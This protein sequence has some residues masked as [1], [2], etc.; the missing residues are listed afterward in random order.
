MSTK[1]IWYPDRSKATEK[2][3][4]LYL[5]VTAATA[6]TLKKAT[7]KIE[8]LMN[9]DLGSLAEDKRREKVSRFQQCVGRSYLLTIIVRSFDDEYSVNGQKRSSLLVWNP[10]AIS[11]SGRRLLDLAYVTDSSA[12]RTRIPSF[13]TG[14]LREIHSTRDECACSNQG[15][16]L[17]FH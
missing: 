7:D 16:G 1:G 2:D 4:P 15:T 5:H 14:Y 13:L 12:E 6:E 9:M 8:E 3:P 11:T 10:F 17:R